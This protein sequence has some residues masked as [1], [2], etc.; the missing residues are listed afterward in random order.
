MTSDN[1]AGNDSPVVD[2]AAGPGRDEAAGPRTGIQPP[3]PGTATG[4]RP[5]SRRLDLDWD[6]EPVHGIDP[7]DSRSGQ[8][9]NLAR[10]LDDVPPHHVDH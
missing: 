7:E 4:I 3:A 9:D 2:A 10:L 6:N 5:P 1:Q 8:A